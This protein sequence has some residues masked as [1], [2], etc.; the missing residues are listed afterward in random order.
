VPK[1]DGDLRFYVDYRALN[2][3]IVKNR[4]ALLLIDKTINRLS[5]T[6]IYIKLNVTIPTYQVIAASGKEVVLG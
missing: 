6:K 1:S 3:F 5:G 2:K 4:H